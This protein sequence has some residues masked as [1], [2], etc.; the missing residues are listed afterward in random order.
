MGIARYRRFLFLIF[1]FAFIAT[2]AFILF[3]AFGY[4]YS[5]ERGIFVYS[6]SVTVS[7]L[8]RTVNI[9][10]DNERLPK[11]RLGLLNN[12]LHVAGLMP[13]EHTL[14]VSAPGYH[15]WEK[16]V[17]VQSGISTEFWNIILTRTDY[18]ADTL[19]NTAR[20]QH[21][22]PSPTGEFFALVKQQND[23]VSVVILNRRTGA[24]EEVFS[25]RGVTLDPNRT[26]NFEWSPR[27][28][29][30]L[31]PLLENGGRAYHLVTIAT[32]EHSRLSDTFPDLELSDVRW[33]ATNGEELVGMSGG[34]L[35][36]LPVLDQTEP[37]LLT[38]NVMAFDVAEDHIY[39][40]R[41]P[42]GIVFRF[43]NTTDGT[44]L[45]QVTA[46]P[47]SNP[48][49]EDYRMDAYNEEGVALLEEGGRQRLSV[50]SPGP[51]GRLAVT[52]VATGVIGMQF[53]NDG[54]KLLFYSKNEIGVFFTENW[55]VQPKQT[56]GDTVQL[57]RFSD[58]I[59]NVVWT[60]DYEHVLF[61]RGPVLKMI[62]LDGRS[63]RTINDIKSFA[64]AP[65]QIFPLFSENRLYVVAPGVDIESIVF[66]EPQGLFGE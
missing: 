59:E 30:L 43:R 56:A 38:E 1:V 6:G 52:E 10:I 33:N 16:R 34:N 44:T 26:E 66:P 22:Y 53:S 36:R 5:F 48:G 51:D 25:L 32:R 47:L 19:P 2:A 64:T 50:Y 42:D 55:D 4:R 14:R 24:A 23:E 62:E 46:T 37:M 63:G 20:A 18:P 11:Q 49:N 45:T 29:R 27:S 39:V 17:V 60:E 15:P 13:G 65:S 40:V 41:R 57:A 28:E 21:I 12:S 9:D 35:Y 8:P 7:T 54:K 58:P 61:T 3:Y 31:L